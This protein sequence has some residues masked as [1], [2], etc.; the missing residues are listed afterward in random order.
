[1]IPKWWI[2]D[3]GPAAAEWYRY[4]T[5]AYLVM[6]WSPVP[7]K[8]RHVGK[9][10]TLNLSRAETSSRWCGKLQ[11]LDGLLLPLHLTLG[12]RGPPI[13]KKGNCITSPVIGGRVS[14]DLSSFWALG[15]QDLQTPL[16]PEDRNLLPENLVSL[17]FP[18]PS[19]PLWAPRRP[20]QA[21]YG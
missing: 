13:K 17:T 2:F 10:G 21:P 9:R 18:D 1:M 5:V 11:I 3:P 16:A 20:P 6:S 12:R 19:E 14:A 4:R 8:T 7:L 15:A